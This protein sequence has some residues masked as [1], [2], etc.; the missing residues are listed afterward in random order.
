M[1]GVSD[2]TVKAWIQDYVA[3]HNVKTDNLLENKEIN[4]S[5]DE[6]KD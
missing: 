4:Q 1:I 2:K 6:D 3:Y 5:N